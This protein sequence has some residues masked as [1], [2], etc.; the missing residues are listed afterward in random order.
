RIRNAGVNLE[1]TDQIRDRLDAALAG[2]DALVVQGGI[3]DVVQGRDLAA[4][5]ADLR[6]M[7][8][9][10]KEGVGLVAVTNV[11]PWN[12]GFPEYAPAIARLNEEIAGI[13]RSE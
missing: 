8:R 3:N 7:V 11:L 5:A 1:R 2:A 9:R 4:A 6:E 10:G 12:N 13:A